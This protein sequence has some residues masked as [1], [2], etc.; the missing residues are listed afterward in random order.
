MTMGEAHKIFPDRGVTCCDNLPMALAQTD[1]V[2]VVT[3]LGGFQP[4]A[5][6]LR[7]QKPQPIV[8]DGR[9]AFA[10]ASIPRYEGIGL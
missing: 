6:Y 9:R 1:A 4:S 5:A 8:V 2:A 7:M 10:K 3:P